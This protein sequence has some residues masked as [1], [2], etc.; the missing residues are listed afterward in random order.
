MEFGVTWPLSR[1]LGLKNI[2]YGKEDADRV[3]CW[4]LHGITLAGK[5]SLLAVHCASRFVAILWDVSPAQWEDLPAL[6]GEAIRRAMSDAGI[7]PPRV[8]WYLA[9][10]GRPRLTRTH[11]RREVAFLN[12]AWDA[13]MLLDELV[14]PDAQEQP[15]LEDAVN[16]MP[17]RC[18][19][20][21]GTA[22]AKEFLARVLEGRV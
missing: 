21:P 11:G 19:G 20:L 7:S 12:K 15:L 3:N 22:T 16:S 17:C 6:A 1:R 9:F 18:A 10:A 14:D 8:A 13:V 2:G 4:D 5:S